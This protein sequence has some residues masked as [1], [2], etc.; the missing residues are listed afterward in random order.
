MPWEH[1]D[2][3]RITNYVGQLPIV[4]REVSSLQRFIALMIGSQGSV[5]SFIQNIVGFT[6]HICL[7]VLVEVVIMTLTEYASNL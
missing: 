1:H 2:G 4:C 7:Y 6:V 5:R 3:L